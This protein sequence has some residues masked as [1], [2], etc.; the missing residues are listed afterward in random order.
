MSNNLILDT[1]VDKEEALEPR[2]FLHDEMT[3]WIKNNMKFNFHVIEQVCNST[4]STIINA[5]FTEN[6]NCRLEVIIDN[7]IVTTTHFTIDLTN[8]LETNKKFVRVISNLMQQVNFL[9]SQIDDLNKK[10][11]I[12][13]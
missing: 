9:T 2:F 6:L 5:N 4:E 8:Q 10:T 1:Y 11:G 7:K 12:I 3:L 13:S